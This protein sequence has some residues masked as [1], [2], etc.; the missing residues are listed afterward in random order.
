MYGDTFS[1]ATLLTINRSDFIKNIKVKFE[2]ECVFIYY[3]LKC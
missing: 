1:K 3:C 2:A